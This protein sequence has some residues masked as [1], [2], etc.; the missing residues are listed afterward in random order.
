[1]T[2]VDQKKKILDLE[3]SLEIFEIF[4]NKPEV[5]TRKFRV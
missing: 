1:M 3:I 2:F 4:F 5:I